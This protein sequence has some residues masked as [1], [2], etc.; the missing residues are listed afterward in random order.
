M[1]ESAQTN[2]MGTNRTANPIGIFGAMSDDGDERPVLP[3][4]FADM[5]LG[6]LATWLRLIGADVAYSNDIDDDTLLRRAEEE[7][8]LVLTRDRAMIDRVCKIPRYFVRWN[9]LD[10]QLRDIVEHFDVT[11]FVPFSRCLRCNVPVRDVDKDTVRQR[12][13]PYVYQTQTRI[14]ECPA[15]RRLY[16][17]ATHAERARDDLARMTNPEFAAIVFGNIR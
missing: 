11:T 13:W 16:W 2:P 9:R 6:R 8:R 12:L 7:H 10:D 3:P 4:A 14:R 15:C 17:G 1:V 5:M